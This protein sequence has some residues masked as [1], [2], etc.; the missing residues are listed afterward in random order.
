MAKFS[1][2]GVS[3]RRAGVDRVVYVIDYGADGGNNVEE[4][5]GPPQ[6]TLALEDVR[7]VEVAELLAYRRFACG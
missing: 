5:E 2:L 6:S 1:D 7:S 3:N 4:D